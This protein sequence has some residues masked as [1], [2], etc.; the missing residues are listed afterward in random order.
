[1]IF[2]GGGDVGTVSVGFERVLDS[3]ARM[4][5]SLAA[6]LACRDEPRAAL[7]AGAESNRRCGNTLLDVKEYLP[8]LTRPVLLSRKGSVERALCSAS[9]F[10]MTVPSQGYNGLRPSIANLEGKQTPGSRSPDSGS[11]WRPDTAMYASTHSDRDHDY[12]DNSAL[13]YMD[14]RS[15]IQC[16]QGAAK[17]RKAMVIATNDQSL[18]R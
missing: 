3:A 13:S 17:D 7:F 1:M 11:L 4:S 10:N 18:W 2:E 12:N 15:P 5:S 6:V 14:L 8:V 9:V 16:L